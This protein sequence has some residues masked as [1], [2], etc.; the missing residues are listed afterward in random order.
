M[1][2]LLSTWVETT[3]IHAKMRQVLAQ[4]IKLVANSIH[5]E[6][7]KRAKRLHNRHVKR[8]VSKLN[9]YGVDP[10]EGVAK[11][12]STGKEIDIEIITDMINAD[13]VGNELFKNL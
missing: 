2:I 8:L 12:L 6:T 11:E 1:W 5:K 10:F 9:D 13:V 4:N 3:H 7:T